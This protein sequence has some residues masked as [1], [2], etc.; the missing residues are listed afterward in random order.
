MTLSAIDGDLVATNIAAFS[1]YAGVVTV[2]AGR[3]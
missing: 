1:A 3:I 2:F